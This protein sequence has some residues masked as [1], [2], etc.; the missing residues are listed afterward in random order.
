MRGHPCTPQTTKG[1]VLFGRYE[2]RGSCGLCDCTGELGGQ[3]RFGTDKPHGKAGGR[4]E[5]GV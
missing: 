4:G 2:K 5:G 3:G 1:G